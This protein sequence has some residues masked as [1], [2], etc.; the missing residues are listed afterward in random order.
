MIL[1]LA[2]RTGTRQAIPLL[3]GHRNGNGKSDK[4]KHKDGSPEHNHI[5]DWILVVKE[6]GGLRFGILMTRFRVVR[7]RAS[8][9]YSRCRMN[10]PY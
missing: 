2:E 8:G 5:R 3:L 9:I 1:T 10:I 7:I 6:T 4:R